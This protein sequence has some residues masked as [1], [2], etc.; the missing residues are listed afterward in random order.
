MNILILGNLGYIGPV[1]I[2]HLRKSWPEAYL[3]GYDNA[4]FASCLLMDEVLPEVKLDKQYYGDVRDITT[5]VFEKEKFDVVIQL[6]AISND[7]MGKTFEAPTFEINTSATEAIAVMAKNHGVRSFVFAS[8]CSVY[9]MDGKKI[10]NESSELAPQTAYAKSKIDSEI[11]LNAIADDTFTVTCLRFATACGISPRIRLDL[12]LNDFVASAL[13]NKRID[14][15]SDG[16]PWRPLIDV[17]DMS[18]AIEWA[19]NREAKNGGSFLAINAGADESNIQVRDL[20]YKVSEELGGI[21]VSVNSDASPDTRSYKV[22]FSLFKELAS[23]YQPLMSL[24]DSINEVGERLMKIDLDKDFRKSSWMRLVYLNN[25]VNNSL[26]DS[27][28]RWIVY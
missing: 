18:R 9:G 19:S 8:S 23:D 1:L 26:I 7:P 28:L 11:K 25:L 21:D 12:V 15:L 10:K 22:D 6:A 2:T 4:Y 17:K 27:H 24:S 14:I 5:V 13:V 3:V 16:T 20:A